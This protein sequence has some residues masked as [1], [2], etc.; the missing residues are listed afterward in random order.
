MY[1]KVETELAELPLEERVEYL[2]SLGVAFETEL[3]EL[4]LKFVAVLMERFIRIHL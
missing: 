3:A 2:K 4:P 1:I